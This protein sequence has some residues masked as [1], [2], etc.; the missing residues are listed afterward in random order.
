MVCTPCGLRKYFWGRIRTAGSVLCVLYPCIDS[1]LSYRVM[2]V[3][4]CM[5]SGNN[6]QAPMANCLGIH[7]YDALCQQ[8]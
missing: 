7:T 5:Y 6:Q 2:F 3:I 4:S 8:V 1:I